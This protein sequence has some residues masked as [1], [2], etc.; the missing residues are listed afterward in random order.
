LKLVDGLTLS[1]L[2]DEMNDRNLEGKFGFQAVFESLCPGF[3]ERP[4]DD[5]CP[6]GTVDPW[7]TLDEEAK[8]FFDEVIPSDP[9]GRLEDDICRCWRLPGDEKD[10]AYQFGKLVES[11]GRIE[12]DGLGR[13]GEP[14][15]EEK[16]IRD[17]LGILGVSD[18]VDHRHEF[19]TF[20]CIRS[21]LFCLVST[22]SCP[23]FLITC[24]WIHNE[25]E[26]I[27]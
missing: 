25:G 1:Q 14:D 4:V 11:G 19:L 24:P 5:F 22:R 16:G 20:R 6:R 7:T 3:G 27:S 21:E 17:K 23:D 12:F 13:L 9:M 10:Y 26:S 18:D 2:P 15:P 8:L